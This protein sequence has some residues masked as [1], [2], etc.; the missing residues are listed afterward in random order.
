MKNIKPAK[1]GLCDHHLLSAMMKWGGHKIP[2]KWK[3]SRLCRKFKTSI[4]NSDLKQN[5]NHL[6]C[7]ETFNTFEKTFFEVLSK[8]LLLKT[9][10]LS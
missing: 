6:E 10:I 5:L 4:F 2:S 8:Y 1:T 9:K 3:I 7:N